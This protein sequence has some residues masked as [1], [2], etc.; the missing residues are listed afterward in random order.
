M[1]EE[2]GDWAENGT[3]ERVERCDAI[4]MRVMAELAWR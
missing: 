3:C 4:K 2:R 1:K